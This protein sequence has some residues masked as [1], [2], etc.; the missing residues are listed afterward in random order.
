MMVGPAIW[1]SPQRGPWLRSPPQPSTKPPINTI[2]ATRAAR[3]NASGMRPNL[4]RV[5]EGEGRGAHR[6]EDPW[7]QGV[8]VV[9]RVRQLEMRGQWSLCPAGA[10]SEE[11]TSELQS[12]A[13][14]V[15]R[16]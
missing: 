15:C 5:R 14:L 12:L 2:G 3:R 7:D 4:I 9:Q 10:R 11:H 16:L 13:Y 1:A 8:D 6:L